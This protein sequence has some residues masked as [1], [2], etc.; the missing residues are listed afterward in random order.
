MMGLEGTHL[1]GC[2][3]PAIHAILDHA[4]VSDHMRQLDDVL[5]AYDQ[6]LKCAWDE[7]DRARWEDD[8]GL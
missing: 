3:T 1:V 5:E 8:G 6:R 7:W 2:P 4:S